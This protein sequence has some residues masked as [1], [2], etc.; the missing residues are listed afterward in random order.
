MLNTI[1]EEDA[2]MVCFMGLNA[3]YKDLKIQK[4]NEWARVPGDTILT[5]AGM[6]ALA[7]TWGLPS[8]VVTTQLDRGEFS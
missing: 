8:S 2:A 4:L 6:K 1:A 7:S 3:A 5:V